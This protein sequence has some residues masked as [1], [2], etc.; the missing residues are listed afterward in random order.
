MLAWLSN[1]LDLALL[2]AKLFIPTS[3]CEIDAVHERELYQLEH[4]GYVIQG[5]L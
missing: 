1:D 5:D 4:K 3:E 2:E